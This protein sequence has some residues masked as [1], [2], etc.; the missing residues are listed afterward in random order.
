MKFKEPI[1]PQVVEQDLRTVGAS[2]KEL[3]GSDHP[4][5]HATAQHFFDVAGAS[6]INF[7]H[8]I[9]PLV[10]IAFVHILN[11]VPQFSG[12]RIRPTLVL[13]MARALS[14]GRKGDSSSSSSLASSPS[15]SKQEMLL[16]TQRRL[17]EITE[18]VWQL[19]L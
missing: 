5:L 3:V 1:S 7:D 11:T 15:S 4:V 19:I 17:S 18:V 13:L 12:K 9:R 6:E 14:V 8:I 2:L 10:M 16:P